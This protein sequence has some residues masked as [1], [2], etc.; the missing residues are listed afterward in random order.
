MVGAAWELKNTTDATASTHFAL[1]GG[2][3]FAGFAALHYW[4]PKMTGRTMGESLARISFWTM[5][6]GIV[7]AFGP[8]FFAGGVQGQVIDAYKFFNG[9]GVDVYNL[10]ATIGSFVLGVG[11]VMTLANAI[12]SRVN[13]PARRPR[14]VG[15]RDA[16]VVR[17]LPAGAA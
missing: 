17:A 10:I 14:P 9:T 3:V 13:G 4:F 12:S 15:R 8:L 5:V 16:R 2:A 11:I 6:V 7:L 1:V